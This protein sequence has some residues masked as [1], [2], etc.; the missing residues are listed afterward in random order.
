MDADGLLHDAADGADLMEAGDDD[1]AR[2]SSAT[3][4]R[5][6]YGDAFED[7]LAEEWADGFR[8]EARAAWLRSLRRLATLRSREGRVDDAQ[9]LLV[10]LLVADPY[11]EQVHHML[12]RTL[13]RAGRHGE[14]RRAFQR[15]QD[16]MRA[17][18]APLPAPAVL[19]LTDPPRPTGERRFG[20]P[21]WRRESRCDATLMR[22][23][24]RYPAATKRLPGQGGRT[25]HQEVRSMSPPRISSHA[26]SPPSSGPR[27]PSCSVWQPLSVP[28]PPVALPPPGD[29]CGDA[30]NV[31]MGGPGDDV[32]PGT[33]G[34][35]V[36]IGGGGDDQIHGGGGNDVVVG[37][38]GDDTLKGG[39]GEDCVEG[40][41]G[42]DD[43]EGG[44]GND[45][46]GGGDDDDWVGGNEG[47]DV[48]D[49]GAG[50]RPPHRHPGQ[51]RE[52]PT[53]ALTRTLPGPRSVRRNL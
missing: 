15:W 40:G 39:D 16:A 35:D 46:V 14:A 19:R 1:R 38:S 42:V 34:D 33:T 36:I 48:V 44:E 32:I 21:G 23:R 41:S 31:I 53:R 5:A 3:S 9:G 12:V 13:A 27:R 7:E 29:D 43:V 10:R 20:D 50:F 11:D 49:G 4:T 30:A 37:G 8:E 47:N 24:H 28:R 51:R 2:R 6:T 45:K 26:S 22:H 25:S 17:I 52:P 18:E